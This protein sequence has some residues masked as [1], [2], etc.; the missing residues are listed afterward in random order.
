MSNLLPKQAV[1]TS[2]DFHNV[3][4]TYVRIPAV[5]TVSATVEVKKG[6][7]LMDC[8]R[9]H[10]VSVLESQIEA[11]IREDY[12][13]SLVL[14]QIK[15]HSSPDANSAHTNRIRNSDHYAKL[16][17]ILRRNFRP[18]DIALRYKRDT[19]A[20]ILPGGVMPINV[21]RDDIRH[22]FAAYGTLSAFGM[23]A[24]Q[25]GSGQYLDAGEMLLSTA[26]SKL[27]ASRA[28]AEYY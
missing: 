14:A 22:H 3:A 23:S 21:I 4:T 1:E 17:N 20:L 26:E 16:V 24:I 27:M 8:D 12:R 10:L 2:L 6:D 7:P 28:L 25:C 11:G 9:A 15:E 5:S 19:I 13:L 18:V